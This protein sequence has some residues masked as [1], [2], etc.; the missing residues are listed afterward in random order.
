[1]NPTEITS[2]QMSE[3]AQGLRARQEPFAFATIVRTA[4]ATAAKPGAKALLSADGTI[5]QGW[6]GGG[7]TRHAIRRAAVDALKAGTPQLVSVVPF[8]LLEEKGVA[9]GNKVDGTLFAGNG[10]PS[11]G[12][13]DIFIEPC[14]PP[15]RL[16]V[17]GA[18]P[19][20]QAISSLAPQF[21]LSVLEKLS[22]KAPHQKKFI[23]IATQGKGDLDALKESIAYDPAYLAFVGSRQK[24]SSLSRQ[25]MNEGFAKVQ[26]E[27]VRSP[28]GL[29]IGAVTPEEIALSILAQIVQER[30]AMLRQNNG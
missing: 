6:L 28:A 2:D 1:M 23:V 5:L 13:V 12:T 19:V 25:L 30:R 15:V 18:S 21:N 27:R 26:I 7:C 10:C 20:A 11:R 14:L 22:E 8:D 3:I 24:Y 17:I 9:E 16:V 29:D 4:G